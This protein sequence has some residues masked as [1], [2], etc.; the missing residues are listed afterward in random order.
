MINKLNKER[1]R[2]GVSPVYAMSLFSG[3]VNN[4]LVVTFELSLLTNG[5][6]LTASCVIFVYIFEKFMDL[7][8]QSEL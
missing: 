6:Y 3:V 1:G 5:K 8:C 2:T 7:K 4:F